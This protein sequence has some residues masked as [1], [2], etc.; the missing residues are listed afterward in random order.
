MDIYRIEDNKNN[1]SNIGLC[2]ICNKSFNNNNNSYVV[3][4]KCYNNEKEKRIKHNN[5]FIDKEGD[6]EYYYYYCLDCNN[7]YC[8]IYIKG[9]EDYP[10]FHCP[11]CGV[12]CNSIKLD[13]KPE[14]IENF[15]N[16]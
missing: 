5:N 15:I 3:C 7:N 8:N 13:Y 10:I 1:T 12:L 4:S 11:L 14:K 6:K 16:V 9:F 2:K